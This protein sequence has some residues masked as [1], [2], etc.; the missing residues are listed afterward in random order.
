MQMTIPG[1]KVPRTWGEL[2]SYS[3]PDQIMAI[4]N[5]VGPAYRENVSET[6]IV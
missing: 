6:E 3:P 4:I 2:N 5:K 1:M